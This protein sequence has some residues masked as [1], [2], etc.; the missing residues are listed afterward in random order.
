MKPHG[1]SPCPRARRS[2]IFDRLFS[3]GVSARR[4]VLLHRRIKLQ[5]EARLDILDGSTVGLLICH[6]WVGG[7]NPS[8]GSRKMEGADQYRISPFLLSLN[9][10][11]LLIL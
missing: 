10:V 6:Q 1:Q 7:S 2:A 4:R 8:V 5:E 11:G 3:M 9:A